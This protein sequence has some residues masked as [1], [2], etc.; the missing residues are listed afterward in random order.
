MLYHRHANDLADIHDQIA[1]P[2]ALPAR[3]KNFNQHGKECGI[4]LN[5]FN[6]VNVPSTIVYQYDVGQLLS[7]LLAPVN[8]ADSSQASLQW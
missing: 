7:L 2:T 5:T 8:N 4:T 3:P 6:V 1:I